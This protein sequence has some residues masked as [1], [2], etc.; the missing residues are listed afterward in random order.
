M[1]ALLGININA[2]DKASRIDEINKAHK[3]W[4]DVRE[5]AR[6]T[7][8]E[9]LYCEATAMVIKLEEE[10]NQLNPIPRLKQMRRDWLHELRRAKAKNSDNAINDA[11]ESLAIID[12]KLKENGV[13]PET[14][15]I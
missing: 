8:N 3:E 12:G 13:D 10:A 1:N 11:C 15:T 9:Q 5:E 6:V 4:E 14:V 7:G 2:A